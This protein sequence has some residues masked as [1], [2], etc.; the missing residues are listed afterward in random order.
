MQTPGVADVLAFLPVP[1]RLRKQRQVLMVWFE[2]KREQGGRLSPPQEE[3]RLLCEM[4]GCAHVVARGAKDVAEYL[5]V[6]GWIVPPR[7]PTP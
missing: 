7:K 6:G 1:P 3:F 2:F 4:A 5:E